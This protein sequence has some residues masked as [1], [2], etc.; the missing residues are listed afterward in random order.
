M[1]G[2]WHLALVY[3]QMQ[4]RS[5]DALRNNWKAL[6]YNP[7]DGAIRRQLQ[8]TL[9]RVVHTR[10]PGVKIDRRSQDI[11]WNLAR[12]ASPDH[13]AVLLARAE[14]LINFGRA[15]EAQPVL[16]RLNELHPR[17]V[18]KTKIGALK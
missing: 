6:K 5:L 13:P 1:L 3:N 10:W 15:D 2:G 9:A 11:I 8:L 4:K 12:S 16:D 7:Y 18:A 14:I 17:L